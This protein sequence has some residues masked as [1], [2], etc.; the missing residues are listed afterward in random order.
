MH[1]GHDWII[2]SNSP[3]ESRYHNYFI[4]SLSMNMLEIEPVLAP[5]KRLFYISVI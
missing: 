5:A 2:F 4:V 3:K 1:I